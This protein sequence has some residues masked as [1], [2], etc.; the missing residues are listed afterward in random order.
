MVTIFNVVFKF[1]VIKKRLTSCDIASHCP[2]ASEIYIS[3]I[4]SPTYNANGKF[5]KSLKKYFNTNRL[6]CHIAVIIG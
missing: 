1:Q 2:L 5:D 4:I 6:V 3:T